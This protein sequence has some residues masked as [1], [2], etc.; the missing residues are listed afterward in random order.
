[1]NHP[2]PVSELVQHLAQQRFK[3][4]RSDVAESAM[5]DHTVQVVT[6]KDADQRLA[7]ELERELNKSP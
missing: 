7:Q 2:I 1:M 6:I 5:A 3:G 4:Q